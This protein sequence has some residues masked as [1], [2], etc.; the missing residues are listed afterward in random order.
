MNVLFI[1]ID[2]L[3][4][5]FV[6]FISG[7]SSTTPFLS[8]LADS[9]TVFTRAIT[10]STWT[11]PVHGSIFTG[12]YPP[13][14]S[15]L[16]KDTALGSVETLAERLRQEG[17]DTT[18]FAGNG[19]LN[20]GDILR[21]FDHQHISPPLSRHWV[22]MISRGVRDSNLSAITKGI[23]NLGKAPFDILRK[24]LIRNNG[25]DR[26]IVKQYSRYLNDTSEPFFHF[27]HLNGVHNPY[28]PHISQYR[29]FGDQST[30][31]V[32][33]VIQYQQEL[34]DNRPLLAAGDKSIDQNSVEIIKDLYRG[35]IRQ[36]DG[37]V[38]E[39]IQLLEQKNCL[40]DTVIVIFGDHGDHLGERNRW[41]HQFSVANEVIRVPLL[42]K[43]PSGYLT[44]SY[45]HDVVQLNDLYNTILTL[46]GLDYSRPH[47]YDLSH[48]S[49]DTAYVYYSA[50]ESYLER[51]NRNHDL[52]DI[53]L[54][55][56]KQFAAWRKSSYRGTW[57]PEQDEKIG[58]PDMVQAI[59]EHY[60]NLEPI[61][62]R[63]SSRID[64]QVEQNLQDM[65]Y[66]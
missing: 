58:D 51:I 4:S 7:E 46:L 33:N 29:K 34:I 13:E 15:V 9:S 5:D 55:P 38:Q 45:R 17:Y 40:E 31:S 49:R 57:F 22:D 28:S 26:R 3:R 47:S 30:S 25:H 44:S 54:P 53:Q 18:S 59:Q 61:Q 66:I 60:A 21:G 37:Y 63:Q 23:S 32:R 24:K 39:L 2:S 42:I 6:P 52:D 10:P 43:D 36:V 14:H 20:V 64:S 48:R 8:T 1:S 35:E 19:W 41:G 56:T 27:V 62:S 16:D 11:L 65:G 12:L 50:P